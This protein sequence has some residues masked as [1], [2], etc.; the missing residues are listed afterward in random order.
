M[1]FCD[2]KLWI[3]CWQME[4]NC[5][6]E[7]LWQNYNV[8]TTIV[9]FSLIGTVYFFSRTLFKLVH[10]QK[11]TQNYRQTLSVELS[12]VCLVKAEQYFPQQH[13]LL[14]MP[15]DKS[16]SVNDGQHVYI[17]NKAVKY[18]ETIFQC[19]IKPWNAIKG[20]FMFQV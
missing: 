13:D 6:A 3:V 18:W 14:I 9:Q 1:Y 2:Y 7:L 20:Y 12:T 15:L 16:W 19:I 11:N 4:T 8:N 10:W 17:N 5:G